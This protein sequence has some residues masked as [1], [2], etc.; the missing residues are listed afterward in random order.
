MSTSVV[1]ARSVRRTCTRASLEALTAGS[2][3]HLVTPEPDH[4]CDKGAPSGSSVVHVCNVKHK[5]VA[6]AILG[7]RSPCLDV[8]DLLSRQQ[9]LKHRQRG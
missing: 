7:S 5:T 2:L 6:Y 3:P 1:T 8:L 4:D 9:P